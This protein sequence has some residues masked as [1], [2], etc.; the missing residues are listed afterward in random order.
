MKWIPFIFLP[1]AANNIFGVVSF[2]LKYG[3]QA[4]YLGS[5]LRA[6][7]FI[8]GVSISIALYKKNKLSI[9]LAKIIFSIGL[10]ASIWGVFFGL[11]VKATITATLASIYLVIFIGCL[12]ILEKNKHFRLVKIKNA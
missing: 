4:I 12:Y 5:G 10:L 3:E 6:L 2:S 11:S 7:F 8:L 1:L 9:S